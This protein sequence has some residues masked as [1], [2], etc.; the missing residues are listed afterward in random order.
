M[1]SLAREYFSSRGVARACS[2]GA[3]VVVLGGALTG[4][5][6]VRNFVQLTEDVGTSGQPSREQFAHIAA[7]GY[8]AVVNLALPTSDDAIPD[9]GSVVTG[10]GMRYVHIPVRF[11]RP[12]VDDLRLFIGAMR[13][14]EGRRVWVHCVVNARV[15]AF[16]YKYLR[17]ERG[18]DDESARSPILEA[19]EP[20]MDDVW[21]S[22]LQLGAE[23]LSGR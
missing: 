14:L 5:E 17:L 3:C 8:D 11:D 16:M 12:T 21:R 22:F 13:A 19:W 6:A 9:E 23:D 18:Y 1:G 10:L 15:S 2:I 20:R 4:V 7:A